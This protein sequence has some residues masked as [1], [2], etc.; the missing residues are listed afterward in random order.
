MATITYYLVRHAQELAQEVN[1]RALLISAEAIC[2]DD[3]LC[4]L[5]QGVDFPTILV[6][7]STQPTIPPGLEGHT[8]VTVPDV[9]LT[10]AGQVRAALLVSLA[11]RILDKGDR[12]VCLIGIDGSRALDSLG[13]LH[14]GSEPELFGG[15]EPITVGS[16]VSPEVFERAL[17]LSAQIAVEGREGRAVGCLFVLGDTD[18]VLAQ[19]R[20]LVLN[21]FRG[22]PESER[23]I[24]DADLDET[25]KEFA[26][27]DG[28]FVVRGDG[29]VLTAGTQL[30]PA[31]AARSLR[32]GL[33][34][35]HAAAA[36]ITAATDAVAICVSQSTGTVSI[37]KSGRLVTDIPRAR[38]F[39]RRSGR[40]KRPGR[41]TPRPPLEEAGTPGGK[42]AGPS[43]A[44]G[45]KS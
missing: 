18:R 33:G 36:G 9:P 11:R 13:V 42:R 19:S 3:E 28:A 34:T 44:A 30:L 27:L 12:V 38:S 7:R 43:I 5:L 2:R 26:A 45:P 39:A 23:N 15:V 6:T 8:W 40:R 1:A 41:S 21:P 20:N 25:L 17:A 24:M 32:G 4:H 14:L 31:G 37:F 10:R 16:D 22:H 35:R 29:T